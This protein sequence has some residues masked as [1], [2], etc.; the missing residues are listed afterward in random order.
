MIKQT[1]LTKKINNRNKAK[2]TLYTALLMVEAL[3]KQL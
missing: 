1:N 3:K 2:S